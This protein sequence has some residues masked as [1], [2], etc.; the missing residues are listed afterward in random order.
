MDNLADA[1]VT[2]GSGDPSLPYFHA[3]KAM[4]NYRLGRFRE[5]IDW[6]EKAVNGPTAE[7][8]AKA[9]AFSVLAMA[10]WRLG[11][12]SAAR[13][14]LAQGNASAPNFVPENRTADLGESWMAWLMARISLEEATTLIDPANS[15]G[16]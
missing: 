3:C 13:V 4:S 9:K 12:Q 15:T 1:A 16:P 8:Q 5:A 11:Q 10:N 7:A 2:L 6:A 14:A